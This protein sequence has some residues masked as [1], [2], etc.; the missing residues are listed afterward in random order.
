MITARSNGS[1]GI[2]NKPFKVIICLVTLMAFLFNTVSYDLA[3]AARTPSELPG[4]GSDRAGSPDSPGFI[5]KEL[6]VDTFT[7]PEYLG[8]IKDSYRAGNTNKTI[9][10]I[11]DAHCNYAAQRKIAE[12]IE[13]LNKQYGIDTINL[14]GGTKEYNLSVFTNINDKGIREKTADYFVK[15]GLVNGAEYFATNNPDKTTLW[16]I[17]DTKLY[18]DNLN[19]YRESLKY[20]DEVDRHLGVLTHILTNLKA[21]IYSQELLELDNKYSQYKAGTIG[22][23]DY[24]NYLIQIAKQ[25]AIDTKAFTNI[26]L[27]SQTLGEEETIDFKKANKQRDDLIDKLQKNLSKKSLEELVLKTVGF[28]SEKISPKDFYSYLTNKSASLG[29]DLKDFPELQKYIVYISMYNAIDKIKTMDEMESLESKIKETLY[30]NDEQRALNKLSKNLAILKNIFSITLTKDDYKYYINDEQSFDVANYA[31]FINKE[32]PLYHI[33]AQLDKNI[34]DLDG[35]RERISKFYEYSFKRDNVFLKNIKFGKNQKIALI[36]TGGF[37]AE[38]LCEKFKKENISYVSIMPNFKSYDG[39]ECPYFRIL[40]GKPSLIESK[41]TTLFSSTL[42]IPDLFNQ[43]STL[44]Y[45]SRQLASLNFYVY[46]V[47]SGKKPLLLKRGNDVLGAIDSAGNVYTKNNLPVIN[48]ETVF[49]TQFTPSLQLATPEA[50]TAPQQPITA[51]ATVPAPNLANAPAST[52]LE[53]GSSNI[54]KQPIPS[55]MV[56]ESFLKKYSPYIYIFSTIAATLFMSAIFSTFIDWSKSNIFVA[57]T[58]ILF[59]AV[60]NY[61]IVD[62]LATKSLKFTK[63]L[64]LPGIQIENGISPKFKT[65][66]YYPILLRS[67][68][69]LIF[70]DENLIPSIENNNDPNIKWVI[71]STSPDGIRELERDRILALQKKYGRDMI[72][73]I[74]R[75]ASMN[76]WEKKRGGYIHF[77][78]WL[79]NSLSADGILDKDPRFPACPAGKVFD[80]IIGDISAL[81]DTK[82]LAMSD[83]DTIWTKDSIK[84]L[85]AKIEH[86]ANK[87][88]GIFQSKM[89]LYNVDESI[90][91]KFSYHI[92]KKYKE[93]GARLWRVLRQVNFVGHGAGWNI[94]RFLNDMAG[95]IKDGYLSHDIVEGIFSKTA[96]LEDVETLDQLSP[97]LFLQVKQWGRWW[98]GNKLAFVFFKKEVPDESR[99]LVKNQA[100]FV[101]KYLIYYSTKNYLSAPILLAFIFVNMI[102]SNFIFFGSLDV[103]KLLYAALI[104]FE[105]Y[106]SVLVGNGSVGDIYKS[107]RSL[108][109]LVL[110]SPINIV[111]I[112]TVIISSYIDD[113]K[114]KIRKTEKKLEWIPQGAL[115]KDL[116]LKQSY[117]NLKYVMLFAIVTICVYHNYMGMGLYYFFGA[118]LISPLIAW[119]TS[120]APPAEG[121]RFWS[122]GA[123]KF[124]AVFLTMLTLSNTGFSAEPPAQPAPAGQVASSQDNQ[125]EKVRNEITARKFQPFLPSGNGREGYILYDHIKDDGYRSPLEGRY[126]RP[127]GFAYQVKMLY[128]TIKG[129]TSFSGFTSENARRELLNLTQ[130]LNKNKDKSGFLPLYVL[131]GDIGHSEVRVDQEGKINMLD[132]AFFILD[133]LAAYGGLCDSSNETDKATIKEIERF[134]GDLKWNLVFDEKTGLFPQHYYPRRPLDQRFDKAE[135]ELKEVYSEGFLAYLVGYLVGGLDIRW[136]ELEQGAILNESPEGTFRWIPKTKHGALYQMPIFLYFEPTLNEALFKANQNLVDASLRISAQNKYLL[137]PLPSPT[138]GSSSYRYSIGGLNDLAADVVDASFSS[139]V[140]AAGFVE[141]AYPGK[142][143][144]L[145]GEVC[146][147]IGSIPDSYTIR[148]GKVVPSLWSATDNAFFMTG[149]LYSRDVRSDILTALKRLPQGQKRYEQLQGILAKTITFK[150]VPTE[151]EVRK[152]KS[153][154]ETKNISASSLLAK[155]IVQFAFP[156]NV[157]EAHPMTGENKLTISYQNPADKWGGYG[158]KFAV[159]Q[160]MR[161]KWINISYATDKEIYVKCELKK[162]KPEGGEVAVGENQKVLLSK[163]ADG[164]TVSFLVPDNDKFEKVTVMTLVVETSRLPA[165]DAKVTINVRDISVSDKPAG[166][167][168]GGINKHVPGNNY[169]T[170]DQIKEIDNI[171]STAEQDGN[172]YSLAQGHQRIADLIGRITR[173]EKEEDLRQFVIDTIGDMP[174]AERF[175]KKLFAIRNELK[176]LSDQLNRGRSN[177]HVN[178]RGLKLKEVRSNDIGFYPQHTKEGVV[179]EKENALP[180]FDRISEGAQTLYVTEGF[181]SKY[182]NANF[183]RNVFAQ[184]ILHSILEYFFDVDHQDSSVMEILFNKEEKPALKGLQ[185]ISDIQREYLSVAAEKKL[186]GYFPDLFNAH[187]YDIGDS[188]RVTAVLEYI[189]AIEKAGLNSDVI[190]NNLQAS[191]QSHISEQG[192]MKRLLNSDNEH[193]KIALNNLTRLGVQHVANQIVANEIKSPVATEGIAGEKQIPTIPTTETFADREN[194]ISNRQAQT[195]EAFNA[196]NRKADTVKVIVGIPIDMNRANVQPTLSVINRGLAKNGFGSREDNKQVITFEIDVNDLAKTTQNQERAMQNAR[197]GLPV[198]GRIVLFAPQME[199]GP[200]IVGK[201]QETYKGEGNIIVVPDAYT[202]SAPEKNLFPDIMLRVALGRNIAF[203]YTGKDPQGTLDIINNLLTRVADGFAPIVTIDDLLNLLKPLRIRPIDYKAITDWQKSQEAVAT[204]A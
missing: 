102:F 139:P 186:T 1:F 26:Y 178:G 44:A 198:D 203:Y 165:D 42:A 135:G 104:S 172:T 124:L 34:T 2:K 91:T 12:I 55:T 145:L 10:H 86:P 112:S 4:G 204:A 116:T 35:Y 161:G 199:K 126:S 148:D 65:I 41:V 179:L 83:S 30:Q 47:A 82:N 27:L 25:R 127:E 122:S 93:N 5:I 144:S 176:I 7:L 72:F 21:K 62:G 99:K 123:T 194:I 29:I 162:D 36:V 107:V 200:Q 113:I 181:E 77:M 180:V 79:K 56:S 111:E 13:Y 182:L 187:D 143:L 85:V 151:D 46:W 106:G 146:R 54:E 51:P 188:F 22:F 166:K 49:A 159:P 94:D 23:K 66:A 202:D 174:F 45:N 87:E 157:P 118:L 69:E 155:D 171:I 16:G 53:G 183:D 24:L 140:G 52:E 57:A 153:A 154:A 38:N 121:I 138:P 9:I 163:T 169:Y 190:I 98:R 141:A 108:A 196:T 117:S 61:N 97:N 152:L 39:Y 129:K 175:A 96:L 31:S 189:H 142:G 201:A 84:G 8:R 90:L 20:K 11:Q 109:M 18:L 158:I 177:L 114:N 95:K 185:T 50:I 197:E 15:E 131:Y 81:K 64:I 128:M 14:E 37:H 132:N 170:I 68:S 133:L 120:R 136:S 156:M 19:V 32:A 6:R 43:I 173:F 195:I 60:L 76:N 168:S 130:Y 134:I 89:G 125:A 191:L 48:F 59:I 193:L 164:Q 103:L 71:F 73:Y 92:F 160:N 33:T 58:N 105:L 40:A 74:H 88:Y 147:S 75:D 63:P 28:R 137:P 150:A 167:R 80:E 115:P 100:T 110:L 70:F 78:L 67:E 101:N 192:F 119:Y 184:T 3:W 149:G 17:E